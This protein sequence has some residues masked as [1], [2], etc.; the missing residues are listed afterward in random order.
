MRDIEIIHRIALS[1]LKGIGPVIARQLVAYVGGVDELFTDPLIDRRILSIPKA[2]PSVLAAIKDRTVLES[3]KRELDFIRQHRVRPLFYLNDDYPRRLKHCSDAPVMLYLQGSGDPNVQK[4]VSIVGTRKATAYGKRL[5]AEMTEGL[6]E[7]GALI[8][9]GLAYG[10]DIHAH[11]S[12]LKNGLP[13]MACVAHGLDRLYPGEHVETAMQMMKDGGLITELSSESAFHPSNFPSRNRMV[14]GMA[15]CTIVIESAKKGGSLITADIAN[16][17]DRDVF[18]VPGPVHAN[19][20]E[21]CNRLIQEH[22][23][24]LVTSA[25]DVI[26]AMGWET[27]EKTKEVQ[28]RLFVELNADQERLVDTL[29]DVGSMSIDELC[30]RSRISQSKA[31]GLLLDLEFNGVVRSLPGKVYTL[32]QN[33]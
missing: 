15:D 32:E 31:A 6:A 23:A 11:R 9:S 21:G 18:A 27:G 1:K 14:A 20:S 4:V 7:T 2:G 29:R 28:T 5:C 10:I 26:R 24:A 8:V 3:A 25:N 19:Y 16:S 13:T 30:S 22:K 33:H 12:A 17:Y